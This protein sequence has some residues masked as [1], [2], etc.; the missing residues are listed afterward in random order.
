M[1]ME[2]LH[3]IAERQLG[4][5]HAT[6]KM[7][8]EIK[9]KAASGL[10]NLHEIAGRQ[11]GGLHATAKM[12]GETKLKA[13]LRTENGGV[14]LR[15]VLAFMAALILCVGLMNWAVDGTVTD[16][17]VASPSILDSQPAGG[18]NQLITDPQGILASSELPSMGVSIGSAQDAPQYFSIF[19]EARGGN[20]P[21]ILVENKAYRLLKSPANVSG[22]LLAEVLGE[23]TEYTLEPALSSGGVVSNVTGQGEPV[24]AVKGMRNAMVAANVNGTMR[25][26]QRV[27]FAGT[28][29]IGNETLA[30]TLCAASDVIY[31][32][33]SDV[34]AISDARAAQRLMGILLNN[35]SYQSASVSSG[36]NQSLLI[37]LKNGFTLQMMVSGDSISACGTWSCPEFFEALV[38]EMAR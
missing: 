33:L 11:L 2:Y 27:S 23:V 5:L 32:E 35:V 28:A 9:L 17:P 30:D 4:G 24:Y 14:R 1:K 10:D 21:M 22:S 15:P 6:T 13:A 7:L 8:G 12:L 3:E 18:E 20:F 36:G 37:G 25:V 38:V 29:V 31:L 16:G 26:F 34:G 19:E